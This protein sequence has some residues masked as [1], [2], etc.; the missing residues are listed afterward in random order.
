M[1]KKGEYHYARDPAKH[2]EKM[3]QYKKLLEKNNIFVK[4][5]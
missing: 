4:S 1:L 3:L 5:A 2:G